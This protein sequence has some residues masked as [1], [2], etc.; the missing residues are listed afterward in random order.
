MQKQITIQH[1]S[2]NHAANE[3]LTQWNDERKNK[4]ETMIV[5]Q[6]QSYLGHFKLSNMVH[7]TALRYHKCMTKCC[8]FRT[9]TVSQTSFGYH[10]FNFVIRHFYREQII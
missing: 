2:T 1:V 7:T 4:T 9:Q 6:Q 10:F 3:E 8:Y 5:L